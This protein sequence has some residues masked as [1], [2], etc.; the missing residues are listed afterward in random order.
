MELLRVLVADRNDAFRAT[1]VELLKTQEMIGVVEQA[2][3]GREAI[4]L[5]YHQRP[6]LIFL[7]HNITSTSKLNVIAEMRRV[8]PDTRIVVMTLQDSETCRT[9]KNILNVE[10]C[11]SKENV[12]REMLTVLGNLPTSPGKNHASRSPRP[13]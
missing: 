4:L 10:A 6:H 2:K 7:D 9:L 1:L 3:S 12:K 11:L 8:S 13:S 5:S